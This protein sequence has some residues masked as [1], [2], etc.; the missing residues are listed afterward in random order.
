MPVTP[1]LSPNLGPD[2]EYWLVMKGRMYHPL[3]VTDLIMSCSYH[4]QQLQQILF[5]YTIKINCML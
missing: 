3:L 5:V 4:K 1:H 2:I